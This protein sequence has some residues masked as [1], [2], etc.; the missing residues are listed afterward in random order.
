M[1]IARDE[2]LLKRRVEEY[3][4]WDKSKTVLALRLALNSHFADF[5]NVSIFGGM[6]RDLARNGKAG[7]QSDVDLVI[8][9]PA[10][11]VRDLAI[12]I[13]AKPNKF[14]GYGFSTERWKID[15]WALETTW[16]LKE[17]HINATTIDDLLQGTFFDWDSV[18]YDIKKRRLHA[19]EGYFE[20]LKSRTL[21][22]NLLA[23]PSSIGNAVRAVRRIISW[24]LRA[25][26]TLIEFVDDVM[27]NNGLDPLIFYEKRKYKTS[28]CASYN[29]P[30]SLLNSLT[31]VNKRPAI[32]ANSPRQLELPGI[33]EKAI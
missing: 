27:R 10:S 3:L 17:G 31:D 21:G 22:V 7:F 12:R 2:K 4:W 14:G 20:K 15:F 11:E 8:D 9:A 26:N 33:L 5:D 19:H 29:S 13:S 28:M 30:D 23:T 25:S 16:A 18:H 32:M 6:I 1:R 24:D